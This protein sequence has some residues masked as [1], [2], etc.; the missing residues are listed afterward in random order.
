LN[1]WTPLVVNKC[2]AV[3]RDVAA[4]ATIIYRA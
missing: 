1:L 4:T 3:D 2:F